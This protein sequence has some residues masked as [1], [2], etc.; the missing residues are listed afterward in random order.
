MA[1]PT[2][3][4][5]VQID[6]K[7]GP[8]LQK[9][10]EMFKALNEQSATMAREMRGELGDAAKFIADDFRAAS[11]AAKELFNPAG[12]QAMA[13]AIH[14]TATATG[15]LENRIKSTHGHLGKLIESLHSLPAILAGAGLGHISH[16]VYE[17]AAEESHAE[18]KNFIA[19]MS[20]EQVRTARELAVKMQAQT[21]GVSIVSGQHLAGS[22]NAV[23]K[24]QEEAERVYPEL[25]K[26]RAALR[27]SHPEEGDEQIDERVHNALKYAETTGANTS[28]AAMGKVLDMLTRAMNFS[29]SMIRPEDPLGMA[30][31]AGTALKML[32]DEG[33]RTAIQLMAEWSGDRTGTFL[34]A[35]Q[36]Y[37]AGTGF[38]NHAAAVKDLVQ[39]GLVDKGDVIRNKRGDPIGVKSNSASLFRLQEM[40]AN[41]LAFIQ[42][43][44]DPAMDRA[45]NSMSD[46]KRNAAIAAFKKQ[47][48]SDV[49][50]DPSHAML[51]A[52]GKE[53][54]INKLDAKQLFSLSELRRMFPNVV[55]ARGLGEIF[56]QQDSIEAKNRKIA[57]AS[58]VDDTIEKAKSD[59][60]AQAKALS[61]AL[62][63]LANV[64]GSPL[65]S[66]AAAGLNVLSTSIS[67]FTKLLAENPAL[68]RLAA[69][70]VAVAGV[71]GAAVAANGLYGLVTAGP[72]LNSAGDKLIEAAGALKGS[73]NGPGVPSRGVQGPGLGSILTN[74]GLLLDAIWRWN[75]INSEDDLKRQYASNVKNDKAW[76]DWL[77][78]KIPALDIFNLDKDGKNFGDR[79]LDVLT[80]KKSNSFLQPEPLS[81]R[82]LDEADYGRARRAQDAARRDP[83]AAHG[84]A[85]QQIALSGSGSVDLHVNVTSSGQVSVTPRGPATVRLDT[86]SQGDRFGDTLNRGPSR[87]DE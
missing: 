85:Y 66:T 20:E 54:D 67:A 62:G 3:T 69:G 40:S 6:D 30:K 8:H 42:N 39:Y 73:A 12:P 68:N 36:K 21:P 10:A 41:P 33:Q 61:T 74:G 29:G 64:V 77:V 43:Q 86:G 27:L 46:A 7:A 81:K 15:E 9:I 60:I 51:G 71:A 55:A 16:G 1:G 34:S 11:L 2:I 70:G 87:R 44:F 13:R 4:A 24:D 47:Y 18:F 63:N 82:A 28:G 32:N 78:Q 35:L 23:M 45:W 72:K 37:S 49:A 26:Y 75:S 83:E 17:K 79:V 25:M 31:Q 59:P 5:I 38:D 57:K 56:I 65:M 22:L 48:Q 80:G 58:G 52:D 14:A 76:N 84:R 50:N 19:G 53:V